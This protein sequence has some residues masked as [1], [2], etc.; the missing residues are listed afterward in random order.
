MELTLLTVGVSFLCLFQNN[1]M[2]NE[3]NNLVLAK[4]SSL[5]HYLDGDW[6]YSSEAPLLQVFNRLLWPFFQILSLIEISIIGRLVGYLFL[7]SGLRRIS[8]HIGLSFGG[9]CIGLLFFV[10]SG[11]SIVS[12]E[13]IFGGFENKVLAYGCVFWALAH[14][15]NHRLITTKGVLETECLDLIQAFFKNKRKIVEQQVID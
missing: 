7:V 10:W 15:F 6:Y 14:Y 4:A 9:L 12:G 13:W 2:G 3:A 5:T 8:A 1:M 11:Q